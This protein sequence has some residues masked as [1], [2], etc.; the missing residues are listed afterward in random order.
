MIAFLCDINVERPNDLQGAE[1]QEA[2][3][4]DQ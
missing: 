1:H 3:H 2:I 4:E